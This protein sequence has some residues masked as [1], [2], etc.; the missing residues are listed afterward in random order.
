LCL[1]LFRTL[2][3]KNVRVPQNRSLALIAACTVLLLLSVTAYAQNL[4]H[5]LPGLLGLEAGR[6]PEPGLYLVDLAARYQADELRDRNGNLI[7]TGPFN[8]SAAVNSFGVSYTTRL[9]SSTMFLTVALSG[10][11]ARVKLNIPNLPETDL[12]R[13][14]PGDPYILPI[15]LGWR[16]ERFDLVASYGIYL[17]TGKSALA[18]GSGV[19][20]GRITHE[21]SAGGSRYFKGRTRF[22]TA[23]AS[24][25]LNMPERGVRI[26]R[27]DTF[28]IEGGA[29]TNLFGRVLETGL[30]S[31]ALWQVRNDRGPDLPPLFVGLRDRVYGLGPEAAVL[32]KPIRSEV[33]S[34]IEW[35]MGVRA[36]PQGYILV[37][38][39]E[40]L[41]HR[42]KQPP[43]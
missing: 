18:G 33:R 1:I 35:D 4:G 13:M 28:Q 2:A 8:F 41:V 3:C 19:S 40:F 31:Y 9:S 17:P 37:V 26:T 29:G 38:G 15:R 21:F 36:R 23:L 7:A 24:Y 30:A 42:P 5:K 32:V 16:K 10:P 34:R 43:P 25:Q 20:S 27:G 14:A 11:V 22:V 6:I 12:D 39:I